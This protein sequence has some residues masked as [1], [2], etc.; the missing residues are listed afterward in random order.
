MCKYKYARNL[1]RL[2]SVTLIVSNLPACEKPQQ[3]QLNVQSRSESGAS[4][5]AKTL[6][7]EDI[8][9][10]IS[11]TPAN[12]A[13]WLRVKFI[14]RSE[15][16]RGI[17]ASELDA[18]WHRVSELKSGIIP[19]DFLSG[20]NGELAWN[21]RYTA[22]GDFDGDGNENH[23]LVGV[24]E[25]KNGKSGAFLLILTPSPSGKLE[26]S[27]LQ[28]FEKPGP[29]DVSWNGK[30]LTLWFCDYCDMFMSI[31]WNEEKVKYEPKIPSFG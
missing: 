4:S 15:S 12:S 14:A 2:V 21:P 5:K 16:V 22:N 10:S 20:K 25:D 19:E 24:Y 1:L 26:M 18:S 28:S 11:D 3:G 6:L 7:H 29:I 8:G 31:V 27:F 23:A 30:E 17:S 13:W 9:L